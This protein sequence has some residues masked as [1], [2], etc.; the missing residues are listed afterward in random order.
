M[1]NWLKAH[2]ESKMTIMEMVNGEASRSTTN[3]VVRRMAN[4]GVTFADAVSLKGTKL[5][6]IAN[7]INFAI[8]FTLTEF[9]D[10]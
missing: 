9:I 3:K 7:S 6:V 10:R 4:K 8:S 2:P 5:L 1:K